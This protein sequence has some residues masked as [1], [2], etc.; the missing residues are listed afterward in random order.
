MRPAIRAGCDLKSSDKKLPVRRERRRR[1]LI[2]AKLLLALLGG[3]DI[4]NSIGAVAAER[5]SEAFHACE[6]KIAFRSRRPFRAAHRTFSLINM[7]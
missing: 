5:G 6:E 2:L 3:V 4:R 1:E 7:G